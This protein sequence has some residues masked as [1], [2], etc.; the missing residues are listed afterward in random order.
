MTNDVQTGARW[1]RRKDR[2][3]VVRTNAQ[4]E[5][6]A[7]QDTTVGS[8]AGRYLPAARDRLA[9]R[10]VERETGTGKQENKGRKVEA[11]VWEDRQTTDI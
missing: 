11:V 9:R 5:K 10:E 8:Q 4:L 3:A 6:E 1:D 2:H 7:G